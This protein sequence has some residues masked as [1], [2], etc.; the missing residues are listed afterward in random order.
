VSQK[1][2]NAGDPLRI[3]A[4]AWNATLQMVAGRTN[5]TMRGSNSGSALGPGELWIRNDSGADCDYLDVL[6]IDSAV[7]DPAGDAVAEAEF[8]FSD[9]AVSGI[10]P[11]DPDHVGRFAVL[12]E[13][14]AAGEIGRGLVAGITP[15]W[16]NVEDAGEAGFAD[17]CHGVST[18][19]STGM[20]GSA[21]VLWRAGLGESPG[22]GEQ[23]AIVLLG[24]PNW[25]PGAGLEYQVLQLQDAG[26]DLL[27]PGW[28]YVRMHP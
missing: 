19:L 25:V 23:W 28:D 17:I 5:P 1:R 12:M 7:F 4:T 2:V 15:A 3:S 22:T 20:Y 26:G 11:V 24:T 9:V 18:Y 14:I 21:R 8:M 27:K 13:P 6:G 16:I 10:T